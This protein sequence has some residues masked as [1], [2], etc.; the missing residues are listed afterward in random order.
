MR[1]E[2]IHHENNLLITVQV[3]YLSLNKRQVI[4]FCTSRPQMVVQ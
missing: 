1:I 2:L 3:C 4:L